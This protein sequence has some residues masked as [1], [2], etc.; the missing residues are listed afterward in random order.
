MSKAANTRLMILQKSVNLIY[1]NGYQATSIDTILATT[2]VTKGA[3][4]YHFKNKDEMGLAMIND[5][6]GPG[7]HD[8]MVKPLTDS[9]DPVKAIYAT[10]RAVLLQVPFLRVKYGC[11]VINLIEEMSPI[12]EQFKTALLDITNGWV[13]AIQQVLVQ[14]QS[15]KKIKSDINARQTAVFI[16]AGYSGIRCIGK[17]MGTS[18]YTTYLKELKSYLERLS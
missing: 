12:N 10:M 8:V 1:K 5:I 9:S 2:K 6:I 7:M 16:M 18:A 15:D 17:V 11:P 3:F 13:S 4:F 14:G